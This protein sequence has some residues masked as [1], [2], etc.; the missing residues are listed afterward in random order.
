MS[1]AWP[2]RALASFVFLASP[3]VFF[4]WIPSTIRMRIGPPIQPG[5]LFPD[6]TDAT[7]DRALTRV[8]DDVQRL[9]DGRR[10]ARRGRRER[11]RG[12]DGG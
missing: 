7:L 2:W 5:D 9:V 4:S 3:L 6:H 8:E 10:D 1:W 11:R 12:R